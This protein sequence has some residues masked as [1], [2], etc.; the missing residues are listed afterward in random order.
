MV[1]LKEYLAAFGISVDDAA[2][3]SF[4]SKIN[5]VK[6]NLNAFAVVASAALVVTGA[7][8]ATLAFAQ[9]ADEIGDTAVKLQISE[10]ALQEWR[11]A[12]EILAVSTET[13]DSSFRKLNATIGKQAN[14]NKEV[15]QAYKDI[16]V[17]LTDT[18]GKAKS[19]E[20][21]FAETIEGL[22]GMG[23]RAKRD[24]A[25]LT[26][27]SRSYSE[28]MG[29][30][31]A[32]PERIKALRDEF[33]KSGGLIP[34]ELIDR[35]GA[36][37]DQI[38]HLNAT[39]LGFKITLASVVL[40]VISWTIDKAQKL[41]EGLNRLAKE[42]S[43]VEAVVTLFGVSTAIA[44]GKLAIASRAALASFAPWLLTIA[45][46]GGFV[47]II[48]DIITAFKGGESYTRDFFGAENIEKFK[49]QMVDLWE[50]L[51]GFFDRLKEAF[52]EVNAGILLIGTLLSATFIKGVGLILSWVGPLKTVG[53]WLFKL[54]GT[55]LSV[56]KTAILF[57]DGLIA[58]AIATAPVWLPIVGVIL[59]IAAAIASAVY[60]VKNW[61]QIVSDF[62]YL[63][64]EI[65]AAMPTAV[66]DA[67]TKIKAFFSETFTWVKEFVGG[68]FD[69]IGE[70]LSSVGDFFGK[71]GNFMTTPVNQFKGP[72]PKGGGNTTQQITNNTP[73]NVTQNIIGAGDPQSVADR[74]NRGIRDAASSSRR[75]TT[76]AL[77]PVK[78]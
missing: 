48:E 78:V 14:G 58:S 40:P 71:V 24:G 27:F 60:V 66:Q 49:T 62:A 25:A 33:R 29:F 67:L 22:A 65:F 55:L 9:M 37:E 42:T 59:L 57:A 50:K 70:K 68:V 35:A 5:H 13:L 31:D 74:S 23:D 36:V 19:A 2:L 15:A 30:F 4:D 47:L 51:K 8:R 26:L 75:A 32:G 11:Y 6:K 52:P 3:D 53:L 56:A 12:G 10:D 17:V 43:I 64:D 1:A 7:T 72:A 54:G 28:L 18:S 21:V 77:V 76:N 61:E 45:A 63:F 41:G 38:T 46:I 20:Q 73:V 16:G 39:M 44:L 69:W 34:K